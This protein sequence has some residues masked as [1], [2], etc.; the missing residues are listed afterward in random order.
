VVGGVALLLIVVG[1]AASPLA[2][3]ASIKVSTNKAMGS[4]DLLNADG[5]KNLSFTVTSSRLSGITLKFDGKKVDGTREGDA[6]VFKPTGLTDGKHT[7]SASAKGRIPGRNSSASKSFTVDTIPP[8]ITI[9]KPGKVDLKGPF[10]L[11]GKVDEAKSLK[12]DGKDVPIG[13]GGSFKV[14]YPKAPLGIVIVAT[15]A[16]GNVTT[17]N[18]D[19]PIVHPG[20]RAVHMTALAWAY[21]PLHDPVVQMLK[22]HRIDTVELDIKD[23]DGAVGYK[24]NVPVAQESGATKDAPYDAAAAVKEIHDLGGRVVGRIVAFKDPLLAKWA[25]NN[26]HHDWDVQDSS[27]NAYHAGTYGT[28]AFTNLASP[29]IQKYNMDLAIEAAGYG[30]DDIMYD[31]IRRPEGPLGSEVY[32]G[33]G[34][35]KAQDVITDFLGKVAPAVH[36]KGA[37]VGAAVFGISAFTA[38][39][40]GDVAQNIPDMSKKID[41]ISPMVYP[42][43]WRPGEYSV[44]QPN[45]SPY[46]IVHRSLMDFNRQALEGH[47]QIIP[48][49]QDFTL[50]PPA[51]GAADVD[52]QI[53]AAHDDGI[54]SFLLWNA[55][56]VFHPDALPPKE[57]FT[58]DAA[59]QLVYSIDKPGVKSDGTTDAAKAKQFLEDYMAGKLNNPN[60]S[61]P[62]AAQGM[63]GTSGS[64]DTGAGTPGIGADVS[65]TASPRPTSTKRPTP[66]HS[67]SPSPH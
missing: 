8:V 29:D 22:D 20:M 13:S 25:W 42:S 1:A 58:P 27:G 50:G 32:P 65:A 40:H 55:K 60:Y 28:A 16:A 15:D 35:R 30:F 33:I 24:S 34:D 51:Y 62:L 59:G 4:E 39:G 7:F 6:L 3:G 31:Y 11:T 18:V 14:D 12:V 21:K 17:Q 49:L 66:S 64:T 5:V 53:K 23:E 61:S 9:D 19:S 45:S 47:A 37:F 56:C 38:A 48:W 52:E 67:A 26:G 41:F 46:D 10:T 44:P 2:A 57:M 43:H 54:N 63:A 36:E